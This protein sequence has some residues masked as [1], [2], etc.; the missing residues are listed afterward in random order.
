MIN[1]WES[2]EGSQQAWEDP[3]VQ[4]A[5]EAAGRNG[6][7]TGG[8]TFEHYKVEDYRQGAAES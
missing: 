2:E 3:E 7:A 5:R 8:S 6:A 4:E 1:L